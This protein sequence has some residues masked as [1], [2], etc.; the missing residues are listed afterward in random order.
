[1][2][3][4]CLSLL[5]VMADRRPLSS[6]CALSTQARR[7]QDARARDEPRPKTRASNQPQ[8]PELWAEDTFQRRLTVTKE[9]VCRVPGQA[10]WVQ[11]SLRTPPIQRL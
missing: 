4:S 9:A 6:G 2:P 11:M 10:G 7:Q 8:G 1:M 3:L 5:V